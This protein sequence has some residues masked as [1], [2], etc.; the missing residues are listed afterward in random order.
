M[1]VH[2]CAIGDMAT[3]VEDEVVANNVSEVDVGFC[4]SA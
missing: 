1:N 3:D 4:C 2:G